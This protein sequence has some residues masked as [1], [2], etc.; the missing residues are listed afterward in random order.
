[1]RFVKT[2]PNRP[3]LL[4]ELGRDTWPA[5]EPTFDDRGGVVATIA[6]A[7]QLPRVA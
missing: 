2:A 4:D 1:L 5:D 3:N 6:I 7:A